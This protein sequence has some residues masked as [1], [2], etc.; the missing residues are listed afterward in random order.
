[1][2]TKEPK[3]LDLVL[4]EKP[5]RLRPSLWSVLQLTAWIDKQELPC[6]EALAWLLV[7]TGFAR[8]L[9]EILHYASELDRTPYEISQ[10]L[11]RLSLLVADHD[12]ERPSDILGTVDR[13]RVAFLA[14]LGALRFRTHNPRD[15][16]LAQV[17]GHLQICLGRTTL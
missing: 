14:E 9:S 5:E 3:V 1:M 7:T 6:R 4:L 16:R 17:V 13:A 8:P 12:W 10:D 11:D 2:E 15:L